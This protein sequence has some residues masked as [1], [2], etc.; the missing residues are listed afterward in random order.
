MQAWFGFS[1][2][3]NLALAALLGF[4]YVFAAWQAGRLAHRL[5]YF[6][7]LKLGFAVM[8]AG[9]FAGS[10]LDSMAGQIFAAAVV[11]IG[12]CATWPTL[13]A[14]VSESETPAGVPRIV[15]VYNITWAEA[16]AAAY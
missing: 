1:D 6:H 12:M 15:G 11:T 7:T 14:L 13:E 3:G 2:K 10:L 4:I 5:G 16:N 9:L 8:I